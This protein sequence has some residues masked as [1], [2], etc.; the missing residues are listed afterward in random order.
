MSMRSDDNRSEYG[1]EKANDTCIYLYKRGQNGYIRYE[2]LNH[3]SK[4]IN[5]DTWRIGTIYLCDDDRQPLKMITQKGADLE[6]VVLLKGDTD[7]LG[8]V[9]GDEQ[10]TEY[11]LFVDGKRYTFESI[12]PVMC[13]EVKIIVNSNIT[14]QDTNNV[15]MLKNKQV[16][17]DKDG[18]TVNSM[19]KTVEE[20]AV[21]SVRSCMFSIQKDCFTHYYD[22]SVYRTPRLRDDPA[23]DNAYIEKRLST[24]VRITDMFY[25]GD[26]T[27]HHWA[28]V[29]GG[30]VTNY[31]TMIVDYGTRL[32]TYFNCYD[33]Y[34]AAAG[35]ELSATNHFYISC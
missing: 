24:D 5:L 32:K 11:F 10:F 8:G 9:H 13:D 18:I 3:I 19:W 31:S 2:F 6:G 16:T 26:V 35:E 25:V 33:G 1:L 21:A 22:S 17:F 12:L 27:A 30:D 29:R 34:I 28:G 4:K 7:H 14:H 15:C 20:L 23:A